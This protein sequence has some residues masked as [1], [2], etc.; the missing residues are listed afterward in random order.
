MPVVDPTLR[1]LG[2]S[3]HRR[4]GPPQPQS[5]SVGL[6]TLSY[7]DSVLAWIEAHRAGVDEALLLDTD[8]HCSRRRRATC[9][10]TTMA[11]S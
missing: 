2:L 11:S 8:G 3:S 6:K 5:M 4:V 9:S 10:C 7:T 1:R